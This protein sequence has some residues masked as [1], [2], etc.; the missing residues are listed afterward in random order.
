MMYCDF[1]FRKGDEVICPSCKKNG[2]VTEDIPIFKAEKL[3]KKCGAYSRLENWQK[4]NT[5]E[6]NA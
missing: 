1:I 5:L 6:E 3:C 4:A 2:F